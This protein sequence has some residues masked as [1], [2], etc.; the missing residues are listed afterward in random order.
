MEVDLLV[1]DD[2]ETEE[3]LS[4]DENLLDVSIEEESEESEPIRRQREKA[5]K[6]VELQDQ[7][8]ANKLLEERKRRKAKERIECIQTAKAHPEQEAPIAK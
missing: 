5:E 8:A 7:L 1:N 6:E 4:A 2:P 3:H